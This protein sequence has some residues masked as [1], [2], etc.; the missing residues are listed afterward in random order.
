GQFNSIVYEENDS[1]RRTDTRWAVLMGRHDIE[2]LGTAPGQC[3]T[4]RS[5]H[6]A[7]TAVKVFEHDLPPGN[8]MAYYPEANCLTGTEVDPRSQT[9]AFKHTA[10][11]IVPVEP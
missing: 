5:A 6:G 7:M 8:V 1:Y 2:Q 9:P 10:V 11:D 4:L 3:V